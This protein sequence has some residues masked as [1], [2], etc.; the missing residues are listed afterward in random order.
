VIAIDTNILLRYL[1]QDDPVQSPKA[2]KLL[3]GR[4]LILITDIVLVEMI[5]TLRG[6]KYKLP[7]HDL[8]NVLSQLIEEPNIVFE[9]SQTIWQALQDYR[10]AEKG[11]EVD[12][13]DTLILAKSQYDVSMRQTHFGGLYTFDKHLQHFKGTKKP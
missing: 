1:L 3:A 10:S 7:K 6:K 9:D 8:V 11:N 4:E 13:A 5:W 12:F 2:N